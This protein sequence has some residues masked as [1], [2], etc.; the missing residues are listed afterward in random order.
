L[1]RRDGEQLL[2][3]PRLNNDSGHVSQAEIDAMFDT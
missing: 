3:G 1:V 2:H